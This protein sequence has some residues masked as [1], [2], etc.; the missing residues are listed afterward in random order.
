M[1]QDPPR[2]SRLSTTPLTDEQLEAAAGPA[3]AAIQKKFEEL[4]Y[5]IT[6]INEIAGQHSAIFN[7]MQRLADTAERIQNSLPSRQ[8]N[9][10][11]KQIL[12]FYEGNNIA[13]I[14]QAKNVLFEDI[15]Y[16]L[17]CLKLRLPKTSI[18]NISAL[19]KNERVSIPNTVIAEDEKLDFIE[20]DTTIL[21]LEKIEHKLTQLETI[22]SKKDEKD[23]AILTTLIQRIAVMQEVLHNLPDC[24]L[25]CACGHELLR[26]QL[27]VVGKIKCPKCGKVRRLP[28]DKDVSIVPILKPTI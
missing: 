24:K 19:I 8:I 26:V 25:M 22:T 10:S 15:G 3:F 14:L 20:T 13:N 7:E 9:T 18:I 27:L 2:K 17:E 4:E 21:Q 5:P 6:K 16:A 23:S 11:V 28:N 1:T 12:A